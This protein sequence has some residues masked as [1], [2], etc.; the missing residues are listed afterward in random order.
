MI[1]TQP[2]F[3]TWTILFLISA[4]HGFVLAWMLYR[5]GNGNIKANKILALIIILFAVSMT[6][7]VAYWTGFA[8][9]YT[10]MN[11]WVAPIPFLYGPL[12][13]LYLTNLNGEVFK[14]KFYLH[15]IPFVF[16]AIFMIPL[17]LRSIF[18]VIPFLRDNYFIPFNQLIT[19]VNY[20]LIVAQCVSMLCYSYCIFLFTKKEGQKINNFAL[21]QEFVKHRWLKQVSWFYFIFSIVGISY[22]VL[23]FAGL[24]KLEYDYAISITISVFIYW[25]GYMGFKQ[26]SVFNEK[27]IQSEQPIGTGEMDVRH[28]KANVKY[29]RST[30]K[31]EE[32]EIYYKKLLHLMETEKPYLQNDLKIQHVA[33]LLKISTHHLSQI[34]NEI[35]GQN[36]TDFINTFRIREAERLLSD[37][38]NNEKILSIAFDVGYSNKATFNT[39]FKKITG[40]SPSDYRKRAMQK[41]VA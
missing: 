33:G 26:P 34:I 23:V 4:L 37:P 40:L 22:W 15:Y 5:H 35:G 16:H 18:G 2:H 27:I 10:W 13:Y 7:Y 14:R 29:E 28:I 6:Y 9:K 19:S 21:P 17:L 32:A 1:E 31:K 41:V 38:A 20:A 25:V 11:G 12:V 30:L 3:D 8:A 24:L 39:A 36:Y